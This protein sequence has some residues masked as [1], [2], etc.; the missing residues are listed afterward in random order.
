MSRMTKPFVFYSDGTPVSVGDLVMWK[1]EEW[2]VFCLWIDNTDKTNVNLWREGFSETK[3]L[4]RANS[5]DLER[6]P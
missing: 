3:P 1:G 2:E 5:N 6:I 4:P